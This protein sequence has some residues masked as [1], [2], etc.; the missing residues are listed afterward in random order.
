MGLTFGNHYCGGKLESSALVFGLGEVGCGMDENQMSCEQPFEGASFAA[1]ACCETT[2]TQLEIEDDYNKLV[3][4]D[5]DVNFEFVAVLFTSYLQQF[6][7]PNPHFSPF[8]AFSPPL[9][10]RDLQ[11]MHQTF[12]I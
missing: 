10:K 1:A 11:V 2:F 3:V 12:L 6:S 7:T 9:L 4:V 5:S 8:L